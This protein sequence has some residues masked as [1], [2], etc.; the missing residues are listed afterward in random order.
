M[1]EPAR[2]GGS[3]RPA[4][5]SAGSPGPGPARTEAAGP[6]APENAWPGSRGVVWMTRMDTA[7]R[8]RKAIAP[9]ETT[10][11]GTVL[12][13]GCERNTAPARPTVV[14]IRSA[15]SATANWGAGSLGS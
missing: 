7:D 1:T 14:L 5:G 10:I 13:A 6:A 15:A 2:P 4:I 12:P 11:T 8:T 9:A 3:P